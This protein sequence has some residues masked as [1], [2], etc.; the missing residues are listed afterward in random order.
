MT[1]KDVKNLFSEE[2]KQKY[3]EHAKKTNGLSFHEFCKKIK[4]DCDEKNENLQFAGG[5]FD[6]YLF[7]LSYDF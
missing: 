7:E 5:F 6:D 4:K 2:A 1:I 3:I